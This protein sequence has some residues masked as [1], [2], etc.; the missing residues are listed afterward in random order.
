MHY[1][2]EQKFRVEDLASVRS[3]LI[4]L[5][6]AVGPT[7]E[8]ADCYYR[9]PA[10]DFATTDEA[11]RL[12][13]VGDANY[14]TYKGP[15][16]DA[17][18]KSRFEREASLGDGPESFEATDEILRRLGFEH[19]AVVRKQRET[20]R[21]ASGGQLIEAALDRVERLGTFVELELSVDATD[22]EMTGVESAKQILAEVAA[23][24]QLVEVERRSYLE[25]LLAAKGV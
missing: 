20:L 11:F 5:G 18:T 13:R 1:E 8:Q 9:H 4:A 10:R 23:R 3:K 17:T 15:K 7:V 22:G 12:R 24:L 21:L 25:L 6:A 19:V 14:M 16:I 2:V